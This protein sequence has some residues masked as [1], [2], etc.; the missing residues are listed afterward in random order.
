MEYKVLIVDDDP[1]TLSLLSHLL[2]KKGYHVETS[3][4]M[5]EALKKIQEDKPDLVLIDIIMDNGGG[6][7]LAEKIRETYDSDEIRLIYSSVMKKD[8][9][10]EKYGEQDMDELGICFYLHKPFNI[11]EFLGVVEETLLDVNNRLK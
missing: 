10:E 8:K 7:Q 5:K 11:R 9:Y 4:T 6:R 3:L 2:I 1:D